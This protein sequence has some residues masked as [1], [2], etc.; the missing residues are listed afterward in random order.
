VAG[1]VRVAARE[2][3]LRVVGHAPG[4]EAGAI[5]IVGG[6]DAA[7]KVNGI[8]VGAAAQIEWFQMV[9]DKSYLL[10]MG[11]GDRAGRGLR[12]PD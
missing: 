6:G 9:G 8:K 10:L 5:E 2:D 11:S 1:V 7:A 12:P 4:D 3:H